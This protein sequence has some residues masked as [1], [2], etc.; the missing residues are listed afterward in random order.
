MIEK[1]LNDTLNS[2]NMI[3]E[4]QIIASNEVTRQ[5]EMAEKKKQAEKEWKNRLQQLLIGIFIPGLFLITLLL[6]KV[7]L[8]VRVIRLLGIF[9]LLFFFEYLTLFLHPT[10]ARLTNHT[11][12]YEILVFVVI[13][14]ILIPMHHRTEHWLIHKLLHRRI[15]Q[16]DK[17]TIADSKKST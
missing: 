16:P 5:I 1:E 2:A 7:N 12:I 9:S 6:S 10:V 4:L 14:A 15:H 3:R 11:P 13:A 17:I 8:H